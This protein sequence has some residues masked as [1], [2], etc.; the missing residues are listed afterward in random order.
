MMRKNSSRGEGPGANKQKEKNC[1]CLPERYR[2]NGEG[3][4][5]RPLLLAENLAHN[6]LTLNLAGSFINLIDF[7]IAH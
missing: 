6:Y 3:V 2:K 5:R 4:N 1:V 7:R